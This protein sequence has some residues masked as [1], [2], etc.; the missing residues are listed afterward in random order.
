MVLSHGERSQLCYVYYED[1]A[2]APSC[3]VVGKLREV[4]RSVRNIRQLIS[5]AQLLRSTLSRS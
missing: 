4:L 5:N 1:T 2:V 3:V